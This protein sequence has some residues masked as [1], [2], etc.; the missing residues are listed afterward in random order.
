MN[1]EVDVEVC[2]RHPVRLGGDPQDEGNKLLLKRA[3]HIRYVRYWNRL[4]AEL[5]AESRKPTG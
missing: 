5:R 3:D 4:I 2:E 1:N